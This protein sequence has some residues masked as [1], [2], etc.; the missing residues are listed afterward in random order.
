MTVL[1][2]LLRVQEHDTTLDQLRHRRETLPERAALADIVNRIVDTDAQL[3][4][5]RAL[6]DDAAGRQAALEAEMTTAENRITEVEKRLYGGTVSAS[7]ELQAMSE[8]VKHLQ[9]RRSAFEDQA[10]EVMEEREPLD[11]EVDRLESLR[12]SLEDDAAAAR[13][14]L[15]LAEDAVDKDIAAVAAERSSVAEGIPADLTATYQKLRDRLGGVGAARLV[16]SNCSGCH[17][18]LP[19]TELDR[20]RHSSGDELFFCD[21]CGRILVR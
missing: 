21:Q 4:A 18:S 8:E 16:G 10:L 15:S 14:A 19:A 17:L 13:E 6:R 1:D 7:R 9:S 2:T 12:T 20:I 11:A 3:A 5:A